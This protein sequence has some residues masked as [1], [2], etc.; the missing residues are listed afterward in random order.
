MFNLKTVYLL[1]KNIFILMVIFSIIDLL[2][3][4]TIVKVFGYPNDLISII[5]SISNYHKVGQI[6]YNP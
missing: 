2:Y 6:A 1:F 5:F 4:G 3:V